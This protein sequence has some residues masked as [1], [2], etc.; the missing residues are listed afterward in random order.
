MKI[1]I[2]RNRKL[3]NGVREKPSWRP[4]TFWVG[5]VWTPRKGRLFPFGKPQGRLA[6]SL[7]NEREGLVQGFLKPPHKSLAINKIECHNH[8]LINRLVRPLIRIVF[9]PLRLCTLV[10]AAQ[11]C[12]LI[13]SNLQRTL[14]EGFCAPLAHPLNFGNA[15]V[16]KRFENKEFFALRF[17]NEEEKKSPDH[18]AHPLRQSFIGL[19]PLQKNIP[20]RITK[21]GLRR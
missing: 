13:L 19:E 8:F 9:P 20:F 17:V 11:G 4:K 15:K 7:G 12:L 10:G 6:L 16:S 14:F 18:Q 5:E 2:R 21:V 3:R 1:C